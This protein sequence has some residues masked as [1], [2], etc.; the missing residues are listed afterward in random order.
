VELYERC[1]CEDQGQRTDQPHGY[2]QFDGTCDGM[3]AQPCGDICKDPAGQKWQRTGQSN[4]SSFDILPPDFRVRVAAMEP[5]ARKE[6]VSERGYDTGTNRDQGES[7]PVHAN[8]SLEQALYS[9]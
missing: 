2:G 6:P 3:N 9:D 5:I 4:G 7:R 8:F 1:V